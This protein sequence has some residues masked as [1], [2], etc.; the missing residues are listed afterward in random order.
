MGQ[1]T[2]LKSK[3]DNQTTKAFAFL[4]MNLECYFRFKMEASKTVNMISN[5]K[6]LLSHCNDVSAAYRLALDLGFTDLSMDLTRGESGPF[7]KDSFS[8]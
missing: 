4:S 2:E 7:L 1:S 5:M 3:S 6:K 8:R